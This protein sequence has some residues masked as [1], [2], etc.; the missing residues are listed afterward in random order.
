MRRRFDHVAVAED[1]PSNQ[2][3]DLRS[4]IIVF[5]NA[6]ARQLTA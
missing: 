4:N 3:V 2:L 1:L 6:G 5:S